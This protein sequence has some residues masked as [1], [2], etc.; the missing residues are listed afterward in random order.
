MGKEARTARSGG[1][2]SAK[3]LAAQALPDAL[4]EA[5]SNKR[6]VIVAGAGISMLPPSSL[7]DWRQF[8]EILLDEAKARALAAVPAGRRSQERD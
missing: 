2:A 5:V 7:P 4:M 3:P 8:N 1:T 6:L